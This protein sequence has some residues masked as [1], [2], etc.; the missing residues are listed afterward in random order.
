MGLKN[1][2]K[3]GMV[4]TIVRLAAANGRLGIRMHDSAEV[5]AIKPENVCRCAPLRDDKEE[6]EVSSGT[7]IRTI[8]RCDGWAESVSTRLPDPIGLAAQK[9]TT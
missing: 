2:A 9:A 5:L 1:G 3:N 4:G 8:S 6:E 7:P